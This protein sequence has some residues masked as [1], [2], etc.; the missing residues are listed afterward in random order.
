M[1]PAIL[2]G[3]ERWGKKMAGQS[4]RVLERSSERLPP[5]QHLTSGFPVLDL[6]IQPDIPLSEWSLE[7]SGELAEPMKLSWDEFSRLRGFRMSA[8]FIVSLLGQSSTA[9]GAV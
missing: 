5:G 6:G 9:D 2:E 3:K 8:I 1:K 4:S 7:L